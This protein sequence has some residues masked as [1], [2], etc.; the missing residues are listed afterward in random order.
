MIKSISDKCIESFCEGL[1]M[2][3]FF[4]KTAQ[5][6]RLETDSK[7]VFDCRKINVSADILET[8]INRYEEIH[9]RGNIQQLM[10]CLLLIGPKVMGYLN[11]NEVEILPGFITEREERTA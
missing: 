4:E 6:C 10:T 11:G 3:T 1:D 7:S 2:C 9:G 5:E 8:W